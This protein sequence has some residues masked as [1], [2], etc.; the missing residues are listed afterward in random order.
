MSLSKNKL[1]RFVVLSRFK[2]CSQRQRVPSNSPRASQL[3]FENYMKSASQKRLEPISFSNKFSLFF[4]SISKSYAE[5]SLFSKLFY[6]SFLSL[7]IFG[8]YLDRQFIEYRDPNGIYSFLSESPEESLMNV[9]RTGDVI[10][11]QRPILSFN[12]LNILRTSLRQF[13][14]DGPYDHCG[15]IIHNGYDNNFPYI[16]EIDQNYSN[17][18]RITAFDERILTAREKSIFIR[19]LQKLNHNIILNYY[20]KFNDWI[21]YKI[22]GFDSENHNLENI[23]EINELFENGIF[24]SRDSLFSILITLCFNGD[25]TVKIRSSIRDLTRKIRQNEYEIATQLKNKTMSSQSTQSL[26]I[27]LNKV[28]TKRYGRVKNIDQL[29]KDTRVLKL[30][31]VLK[32]DNL[33]KRDKNIRTHMKI[34]SSQW[35][36]YIWKYLQLLDENCVKPC[37]IRPQH[38]ADSKLEIPMIGNTRLGHVQFLKTQNET[39]KINDAERRFREAKLNKWER[40]LQ[41]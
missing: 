27:Q 38:F 41:K 12:P 22:N 19:Q 26:N 15:I 18:L 17:K 21:D 30:Q 20:N 6:G 32:N 2:F 8:D 33:K 13:T 40:E 16:V 28:Q 24:H 39:D 3:S 36:G 14:C 23:S 5:L 9:C 1:L 7:I 37:E 10:V 11:F 4:E 31:R 25:N 35:I 29:I 34:N